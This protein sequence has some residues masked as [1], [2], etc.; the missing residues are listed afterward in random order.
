MGR[1]EYEARLTELINENAD[2]L[3]VLLLRSVVV[4]PGP[5]VEPEPPIEPEPPPEPEPE[6]E[7]PDPIPPQPVGKPGPS[8]TGPSAPSILV[9][10]NSFKVTQD[11]AI[12]ENVDVNGIIKV[13]A[14]NVT[15]R[16]FRVNGASWYGVKMVNGFTGL[17]LEDG[18]IR[19]SLSAG[20]LGSNFTARRLDVHDI[21]GDG[22]KPSSN[23]V[24]ERCWVHR[25]GTSPGAH[26][27]GVQIRGG[28]N[29]VIRGN[30]FDMPIP[31]PAGYSSN[32]C[33]MMDSGL[34]PLSNLLVEGNWLSGGNYTIY[35]TLGS[36][37][38]GVSN[39]TLRD[40]RF[41]RSYRY[42]PLRHTAGGAVISGNVWDVTGQ[43][44]EINNV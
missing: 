10:S 15:I 14:N 39:A 5:P 36:G 33:L 21:G 23:T 41:T 26:A 42:G 22:F 31:P 32:A 16:N 24:I 7:P 40:N 25:L 43:L 11:N 34:E 1:A 20:V 6:P 2:E 13:A 37:A 12:I 44:M 8:N 28:T 19:N 3:A 30:F 29:I 17:V 18:E 27:D 38:H 9:P 35:L 4:D